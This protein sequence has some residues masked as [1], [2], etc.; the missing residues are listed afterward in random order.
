MSGEIVKLLE[1][2]QG[3]DLGLLAN[4][5]QKLIKLFSMTV[6]Y[7]KGVGSL[8]VSGSGIPSLIIAAAI[9]Y[10]IFS[11]GLLKNWKLVLGAVV[12]ALIL[13]SLGY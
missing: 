3:M 11:E 5:V 6:N 4:F 10:A 1:M 9:L 2:L 7:T 13:S 8:F 12:T